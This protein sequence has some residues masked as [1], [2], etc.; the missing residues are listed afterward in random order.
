MI[1]TKTRRVTITGTALLLCLGLVTAGTSIVG[2]GA[3]TKKVPGVTAHQ[4]TIGATEPMTGIASSG[5]NQVAIAANAV[6]KYVNKH[7]GIYGRTIKYVI[8]DDCYGTPGFGCTGTPST[9]TQ[10]HALLSVPVFATVGSLG[11]PTQDSVR[12]LLTSNR[13][14]QLFV[15]SGSRDWNNPSAYPGLFGWQT[16]YNEESKVFAKY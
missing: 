5:Y 2:A 11:T 16:S 10:T 9:V 13:V 4:I 15:N 3:A 7:G 6:F 12:S 14:P 8:K 1:I